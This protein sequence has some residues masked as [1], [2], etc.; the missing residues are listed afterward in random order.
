MIACAAFLSGYCVPIFAQDSGQPS[1]AEIIRKLTP[2]VQP[3]NP[4][5]D[6]PGEPTQVPSRS[7]ATRGI[8]VENRTERV[9]APPGLDLQVNFEYAS[10]RLTPDARIVLDSLGQALNDPA[11]RES[12]MRIAGHTDARGADAYN[13]TLSRQ[14]AQSVADYLAR[15]HGVEA[16]R[17]SVEGFGR[18]Q[19][20]DPANP[21]S[22]VNRRV[23]V[24]NLGK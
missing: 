1:A 24:V 20:F 13:L 7:I 9:Q 8:K 14:R 21:G 22:A 12:R 19:L 18:G 4:G 17:L 10:A 11:L 6:T 2:A 3:Q 16:A 15:Q 23:Q 5:E